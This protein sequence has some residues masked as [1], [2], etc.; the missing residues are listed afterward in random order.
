M[1]NQKKDP[2]LAYPLHNISSMGAQYIHSN[3]IYFANTVKTYESDLKKLTNSLR[4]LIINYLGEEMSFYRQAQEE[5]VKIVVQNSEGSLSNKDDILRHF[6]F[7][8]NS[9]RKNKATN[10][11]KIDFIKKDLE[12]NSKYAWA[13][14]SVNKNKKFKSRSESSRG[15]SLED[16]QRD[17]PII[18]RGIFEYL[19]FASQKSNLEY[20]RNS[21]YGKGKKGKMPKSL[22]RLSKSSRD[23]IEKQLT[24]IQQKLEEGNFTIKDLDKIQKI[25]NKLHLHSW[26]GLLAEDFQEE[27]IAQYFPALITTKNLKDKNFGKMSS[28]YMDVNIIDVG[29]GTVETSFGKTLIGLSQKFTNQEFIGPKSYKNQDIFHSIENYAN[30]K[31]SKTTNNQRATLKKMEP[32]FYYIRKNLIALNSFALDPQNR[33]MFNMDQFI[34]LESELTILRNFLRFFNGFMEMLEDGTLQVFSNQAKSELEAPLIF[35]A[36]LAFRQNIYWVI[37]FIEPIYQSILTSKRINVN[38]FTATTELKEFPNVRKTAGSLWNAK[39]KKIRE[40]RKEMKGTDSEFK[41]TYSDLES[42]T[43]DVLEKLSSQTGN[44]L[45]DSI[46]YEL[47]P[48]KFFKTKK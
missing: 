13:K 31:M 48:G 29:L 11:G 43:Q 21:K 40:M 16:A 23:V 30:A 9:Q 15:K 25:I 24:A 6:R 8:Y 3:W 45:I 32:V 1:F 27:L 12:V 17:I 28:Q 14:K 26:T 7:K 33:E 39:L 37:D 38:G 36:F 47:D 41:I 10:F 5:Y 2:T 46:V 42:A 35:N 34:E 4:T 20:L 18:I 19:D 22:K 44:L